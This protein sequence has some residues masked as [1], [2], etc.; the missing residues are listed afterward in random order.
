MEAA[1]EYI[2]KVSRDMGEI[3]VDIGEPRLTV[4]FAGRWLVEPD[5]DETRPGP[6]GP[7]T[8]RVLTGVLPDQ[9]FRFAVFAASRHDRWTA[10]LH[11]YDSLDAAAN[12]GVPG[13]I[14]ALPLPNS[15]E[16][17]FSGGTCDT[18]FA[19]REASSFSTY[20]SMSGAAV[21]AYSGPW[22]TMIDGVVATAVLFGLVL[23]A[24]PGWWWADPAAGYLSACY[25]GR[26]VREIVAAP[27][28]T[29]GM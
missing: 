13:E 28:G 6:A 24:A 18:L 9:A 16:P 25:A 23:N 1:R 7:A 22:V 19:A 17:G 2:R 14:I 4:G 12:D 10:S 21:L 15:G 27:A 29:E 5:P 8:T 20:T 26:E 3:T 11:A